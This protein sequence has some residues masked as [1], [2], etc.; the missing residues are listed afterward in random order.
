MKGPFVYPRRYPPSREPRAPRWERLIKMPVGWVMDR[1]S[2][3]FVRW[4][5]HALVTPEVTLRV[6]G[7]P[8]AFH[9]FRIALVSDLHGG[10][11]VPRW[12]VEHLASRVEALRPDLVALAGDFVSH[13][14]RDLVG[15][16]EVL[17]RFAAP[18]GVVAVLGNHDHWIGT[19][20]VIPVLQ[21]AGAR[22]LVNH[23]LTIRRGDGMIVVAGV[24][25]FAHGAVRLDEALDGVPPA[26]PRVLISHNPDLVEYLPPGLRVDVMLSGHTHN[27]QL[28][29]PVVG[30]ITVPSQF[31]AAYLQGLKRCGETQVYVSAGVGTASIPFRWGNPPEL[32]VLVLEPGGD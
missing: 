5:A 16:D 24:D 1:L 18:E 30:P 4:S 31:G 14:R 17:A 12:W 27:G 25:D 8:A 21:R 32:P 7:L 15:L 13:S 19:E 2:A 10:P 20:H 6:R 9:G 22:V 3:P 26:I 29:L 28:H 11:C 23:R